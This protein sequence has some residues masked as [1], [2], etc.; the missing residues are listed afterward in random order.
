MKR[1]HWILGLAAAC[2]APLVAQMATPSTESSEAVLK[3]ARSRLGAGY[4]APAKWPDSLALLPKP[5]AQGSKALRR[6]EKLQARAVA[7]QS[8]A[9]WAQARTDAD[10]FLPTAT[11]TLSC[12]AGLSIGS[13]TTPVIDKILRRTMADF[14][15]A[16]AKAK[17]FYMR[18][19]PFTINQKPQCTPDWDKVL[20]G[21]GSY[22]SGHAAIGYGWGLTLAEIV[23]RRKSALIKRGR[24]FAESRRYCNV[25]WQSDVEAGIE[26]S[27][28]VF[29]KLKAD[30]A[31]QADLAAGRAEAKAATSPPQNCAA[32]KAALAIR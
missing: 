27:K 30:P 22:P 15:S 8:T 20:R 17:A 10:I 24:A 31:F 16:T 21:D 9:R 5:P 12:A 25:H 29:A 13:T 19:R 2:A 3:S 1:A 28:A 6:D 11:A 4:L 32:E 26:V 14:G 23:P 7:A 18:P